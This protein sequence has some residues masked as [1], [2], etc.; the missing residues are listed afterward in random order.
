MGNWCGLGLHLIFLCVFLVANT[1]TCLGVRNTS[2]I[3]CSQQERLALLKFKNSVRD[4]AGMLSS[5]VGNDCCLWRGIQC[6]GVSGNIQRLDLKGDYP[7]IYSYYY[8]YYLAGNSASSSLAELRHLKYLDLS[9]NNFHGII[10]EFIGS[11]KQLTYL[12][13]S[14]AS[15]NGIIPPHIGNLS[16][17]KVLDL[18]SN[19]GLIADDMAWAFGLSSLELLDLSLVVFTEAQDWGMVLHMMPS[20]IKLSL[21][22]CGLSNA[23]LGPFLNSSRILPN[24]Q[25]LDLGYN[26]FKAPFPAFFQNMTSLAFLDLSYFN[27]SSGSNFAKLLNM[28]PSLS[29]LHLSDCSLDM[30]HLSSHRLNFSTFFN[31]QHLDLSNNPLEGDFPS[32]LANMTSLRVLDLSETM[33]NSSLPIMPK[34]TGLDLSRNKFMQVEDVGIWRQCHLK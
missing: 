1:Y 2:V 5:W 9:G 4:R 7:Y 11:L 6:D 27:L 22:W 29:E 14:H 23:D 24:I 34:L 16:N 8:D 15:F 13:L 18:S 19:R 33:L 17:L 28:I 21:S 20:L 26:S 10:P 12:N 31:I 25:H 30:T 3:N 32:F